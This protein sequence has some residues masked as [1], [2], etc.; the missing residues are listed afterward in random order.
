MQRVVLHDRKAMKRERRAKQ[1]KEAEAAAAAAAALVAMAAEAAAAEAA[2]LDQEMDEEM[3]EEI[4]DE[5]DV[6]Q[7]QDRDHDTDMDKDRDQEK[8]PESAADNGN[9]GGSDFEM[10]DSDEV[11]EDWETSNRAK[12]DQDSAVLFIEY[13]PRGRL[14]DYIGRSGRAGVRVPD[15]VLWRMFE[16]RKSMLWEKAG[17][18]RRRGLT[19]STVFRGVI[20]MAYPDAFQPVGCDPKTENAPQVSESCEGFP[21]LTSHC[22]RET[23][24]HF[25]LDPLNGE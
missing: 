23:M 20:G 24:V 14:D 21:I 19:T 6:S 1:R 17:A 3:D 11:K 18:G 15:Q 5:M 10:V 25:D 8:A 16:C 2:E 22:T 12:L 7:D 4:D 13:M 9:R